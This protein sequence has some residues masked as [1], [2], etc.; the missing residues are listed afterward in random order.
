MVRAYFF[1]FAFFFLRGDEGVGIVLKL[2]V[3]Y[4]LR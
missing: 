3:L 4:E 2:L 1:A